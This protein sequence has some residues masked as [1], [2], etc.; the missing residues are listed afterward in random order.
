MGGLFLAIGFIVAGVLR[1]GLII[2][3]GIL[4][5]MG[6]GVGLA[7]TT[8][9]VLKWFG[10]QRQGLIAGLIMGNAAGVV[11]IS[12][13]AAKLLGCSIG[14]S[15]SFIWL[16]MFFAIVVA[17]AGTL[18]ARPPEHY[19][20]PAV[21]K[22]VSTT[23]DW[24]AATMVK[25]WQFYALVIMLFCSSQ[26]GLMLF[27]NVRWL[28]NYVHYPFLSA[29]NVWFLYSFAGAAMALGALATYGTLKFWG[30]KLLIILIA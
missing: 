20:P 25:T 19:V 21:P 6:M 16:G 2:G 18:M 1:S 29:E 28:A 4:G 11:F 30:I 7:A 24:G 14:L 8:S 26:S 23:I 5:G 12:P 22:A 13:L 10:P 17:V 15:Y 27:A 9:A 3:F